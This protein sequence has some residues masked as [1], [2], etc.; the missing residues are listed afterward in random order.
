MSAVSA[1]WL[2]SHSQHSQDQELSDYRRV[3][4]TVHALV[5]SGVDHSC[6]LLHGVSVSETAAPATDGG[7]SG[8]WDPGT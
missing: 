2:L 6:A 4:T 5:M 7:E 8:D 3:K 1:R